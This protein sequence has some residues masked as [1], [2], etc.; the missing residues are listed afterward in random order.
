[1]QPQNEIRAKIPEMHRLL[2]ASLGDPEVLHRSSPL[3]YCDN[4]LEVLLATILTQATSDKNALKA[5]QNIKRLCREPQRILELDEAVFINAIQPAGIMSRRSQTIRGVL[6]AV[7]QKLG[8]YSLEPLAKDPKM[9]WEILNSLPGVG[10]KTA[11]CTM[12]FG[13]G[14]P[15]FPV[16][17]HIHRI[18]RRIGWVD[19]RSNPVDTQF[20]LGK[21]IPIEYQAG[22]H[23]LLLNLGRRYC[24]P[25][26]PD[27]GNCPIH[28][29]CEFVKTMQ[30]TN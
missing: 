26:E 25:K 20:V 22:L 18:A 14:L 21:V 11:A 19:S 2:A 8:E 13:L 29:S 28:P 3:Y 9:A 7:E 24:R 15:G 23:I 1:M 5:W 4:A 27:C 30:I 12:L 10:P 17:T 16:D 6:Q